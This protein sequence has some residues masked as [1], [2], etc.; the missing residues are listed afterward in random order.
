[1]AEVKIG[2]RYQ[3]YKNKKL[4]DV[5]MVATHSETEEEMVV[6]KALYEPFGNWARPKK[7]FKENVE[8]E[9]EVMPRFSLV[10]EG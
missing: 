2:A 3:H 6:Y 10:A 7:M 9:G 1:M 5:L 8:H 4:Y